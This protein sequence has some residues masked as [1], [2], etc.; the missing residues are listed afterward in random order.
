[1]SDVLP[2][3]GVNIRLICLTLLARL[4]RYIRGIRVIPPKGPGIPSDLQLLLFFDT[5]TVECLG[6]LVPTD[7]IVQERLVLLDL[8]RG[9]EAVHRPGKENVGLNGEIDIA[10]PGNKK[11]VGNR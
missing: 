5:L 9:H 1:M 8:H 11:C 7:S 10:K 4:V 2:F 3:I 6:V